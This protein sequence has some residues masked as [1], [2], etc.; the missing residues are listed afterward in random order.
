MI[1]VTLFLFL[2]SATS[3]VCMQ[4]YKWPHE[5]GDMYECMIGGYEEA[6]RKTK[7]LGS[8]EVNKHQIFVKFEC[9]TSEVIIPKKKPSIKEEEKI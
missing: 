6:A 4:P 7:E 8:E 5:F 2:C 3:N 1:K 9:H